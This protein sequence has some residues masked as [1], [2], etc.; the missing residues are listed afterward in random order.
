LGALISVTDEPSFD[1]FGDLNL[2]EGRSVVAAS[3][4]S[5]PTGHK[6]A[7]ERLFIITVYA[8]GQYSK[9]DIG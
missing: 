3:A 7:G 5:H 2:P 4:A 9:L 1:A 6:R 8:D